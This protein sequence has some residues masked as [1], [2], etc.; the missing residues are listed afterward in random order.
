MP[1]D[2]RYGFLG[3]DVALEQQGSVRG[4][5]LIVDQRGDPLELQVATP[6]RPNAVQRA[7]WGDA[8]ARHVIVSVLG[9]P[10]LERVELEPD[11]FF[12]NRIEALELSSHAPLAQLQPGRD[13]PNPDAPY[14][15]V[16]LGAEQG[17]L[18]VSRDARAHTLSAAVASLEDMHELLNP[19]SVF[20]RIVYALTALAETNDRYA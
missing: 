3:F 11:A 17:C 15:W 7:I 20:K 14:E 16:M 2:L 13:A 9:E 8:L 10:L 19:L 1:T 4:A 5:L 12:T 18:T 6:V